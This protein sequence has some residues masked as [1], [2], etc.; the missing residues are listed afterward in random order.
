MPLDGRQIPTVEWLYLALLLPFLHFEGAMAP[1]LALG[2]PFVLFI[3]LTALPYLFRLGNEQRTKPETVAE[4]I[5]AKLARLLGAGDRSKAVRGT[6]AFVVVLVFVAGVFGP[7]YSGVHE[8]PTYGCNSCHNVAMGT[9]MGVP[10]A[11]FKDRNV[12]PTLEDNR[13]MVE[14]WFYPQVV[15]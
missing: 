6:V 4:Q 2:L 9:R 3:L 15:W 8:S 12:V 5:V 14:H 10:P 11:A 13:W 7:L 1:L